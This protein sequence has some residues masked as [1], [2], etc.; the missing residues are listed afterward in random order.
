MKVFI[1]CN[2]YEKAEF[3]DYEHRATAL[4]RKKCLFKRN[5]KL[6]NNYENEN[7]EER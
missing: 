3:K 4:K 7:D 1:M 6:K 5:T 2:A